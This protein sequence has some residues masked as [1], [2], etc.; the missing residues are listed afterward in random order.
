MALYEVET[1]LIVHTKVRVTVEADSKDAAIDA[2]ADLLPSN[3]DPGASR[4]G[5]GTVD[6][7]PTKG[8]QTKVVQDYHSEHAGDADK[9]RKLAVT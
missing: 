3:N 4:R 2:A 8:V 5:R 1:D 7:K 6:L 9:A